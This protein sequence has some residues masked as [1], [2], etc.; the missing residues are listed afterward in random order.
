[1]K[2]RGLSLIAVAILAVST[3]S[4]LFGQATAQSEENLTIEKIVVTPLEGRAWKDG[5]MRAV[6]EYCPA[7]SGERSAVWKEWVMV[8]VFIQRASSDLQK[9][10]VWHGG[11]IKTT[12]SQGKLIPSASVI[13]GPSE[14]DEK[15]QML[16]SEQEPPPAITRHYVMDFEISLPQSYAAKDEITFQSRV[17]DGNGLV[18]PVSVIIPRK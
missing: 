12:D 17:S 16:N 13:T 1:M 14:M 5:S 10:P 6:V 18:L 8:R 7:K 3:V 15:G 4:Y 9:A 11:L 2:H